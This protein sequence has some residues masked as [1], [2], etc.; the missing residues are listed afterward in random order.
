[1]AKAELK[2]TQTSAMILLLRVPSPWS[3]IL[4]ED[5][6]ATIQSSNLKIDVLTVSDC[7]DHRNL[8]IESPVTRLAGCH[9]ASG[10]S[11]EPC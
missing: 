7:G 1:M 11:G 9:H 6:P 8:C 4:S 3:F 10:I 2:E 5:P